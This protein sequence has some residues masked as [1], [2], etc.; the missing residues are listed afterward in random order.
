[1][2]SARKQSGKMFVAGGGGINRIHLDC[3][4]NAQTLE[5]WSTGLNGRV[6]V[7]LGC[8]QWGCPVCGAAK[9]RRL[10]HRVEAA[11]PTKFVTLTTWT[12][13][14]LGPRMAFEKGSRKIPKLIAKLRKRF[15]DIEYCKV[16]EQHKNGFPHW[17]FAWRSSYIPQR[18][19]SDLWDELHNSPIVHIKRVEKIKSVYGYMVKYLCKQHY[20]PWTDRRVS[21]SRGFWLDKDDYVSPLGQLYEPLTRKSH[22]ANVLAVDFEGREFQQVNRSTWLLV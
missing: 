19:I 4:P 5:A 22:P 1:M 20:V 18:I 13:A 12:R 21:W 14:Y 17:H 9:V 2:V 10:A 8:K 7:A 3:C 6:I 11:K 16:L 15:G